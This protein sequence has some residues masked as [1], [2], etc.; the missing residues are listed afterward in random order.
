MSICFLFLFLFLFFFFF[1]FFCFISSH[2]WF[3]FYAA[4]PSCKFMANFGHSPYPYTFCNMAGVLVFFS[5]Q[6]LTPYLDILDMSRNGCFLA[7]KLFGNTDTLGS[8][9]LGVYNAS[10][11]GIDRVAS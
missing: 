11:S 3:L 7:L 1:F 10:W 8:I 2:F 6:L 4:V 5:G 9:Y